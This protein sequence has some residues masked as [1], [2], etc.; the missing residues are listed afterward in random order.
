MCEICRGYFCYPSCPSF[1]GE[2]AE[3]GR[4]LFLCCLCGCVIYETDDYAMDKG[5]WYCTECAEVIKEEN[6]NRD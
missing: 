2:S 1:A 3:L 4:R 6:G 5:K